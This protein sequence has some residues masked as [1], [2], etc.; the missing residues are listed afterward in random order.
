MPSVSGT[1]LSNYTS[2]DPTQIHI[3][4][5]GISPHEVHKCRHCTESIHDLYYLDIASTFQ[6]HLTCLKCSICKCV[7]RTKCFIKNGKFYCK[8]D[9]QRLIEQHNSMVPQKNVVHNELACRT[10]YK[11]IQPNEYVIRL[12]ENFI[13][14]YTC[15]FCYLCLKH[16]KPGEKYGIINHT[17]FCG[18]HYAEQTGNY[19]PIEMSNE[20]RLSSPLLYAQSSVQ[21]TDP[22]SSSPYADDFFVDAQPN[23]NSVQSM[24]RI[25]E[26]SVQT[27]TTGFHDGEDDHDSQYAPLAC[28]HDWPHSDDLACIFENDGMK[29]KRK[30]KKIRF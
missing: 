26:H 14:H 22:S 10:C 18:H 23:C 12:D 15:F 7:L 29:R 8:H 28:T 16:I 17:L 2:S 13:Y 19:D 4:Y 30:G 20:M 21:S 11:T 1:L 6:W 3:K 24:S 9:Y 27:T 5:S 25:H